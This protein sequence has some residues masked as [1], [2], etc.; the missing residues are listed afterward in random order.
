MSK[1]FVKKAA[2]IGGMLFLLIAFLCGSALAQK[3]GAKVQPNLYEVHTR[4]LWDLGWVSD[5]TVLTSGYFTFNDVP[6][7]LVYADGSRTLFL[8]PLEGYGVPEKPK[9]AYRKVRLFV[10]YGHQEACGG[11][12]T[13]RIVS[14]NGEVEFSLPIIGGS[15]GDVAANWSDFKDLSEY[16]GIG[17]ANIQVYQK[18]ATGA[19]SIRGAMYRIEAHFYDGYGKNWA[20]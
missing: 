10:S 19:C 5:S 3:N 7:N 17:H 4:V 16:Q 1:R 15:F 8:S 12:P 2:L 11:T 18:D 6:K 20:P 9:N 13:V 14:G